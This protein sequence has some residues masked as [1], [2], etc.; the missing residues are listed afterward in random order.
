M[1]L[2]IHSR[3]EL[4]NQL[5]CMHQQGWSIRELTRR[6]AMSR[7]TVRRILRLQMRH[8]SEGH[9]VLSQKTKASRGSKLDPFETRIKELTTKYT[10]I[11]GQRVFEEE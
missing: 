8:R 6:F 10:S 2:I 5:I 7:N 3:E 11:T 1:V 4:E 9:D